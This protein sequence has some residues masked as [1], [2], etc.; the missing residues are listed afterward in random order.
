MQKN[1]LLKIKRIASIMLGFLCLLLGMVFILLPGPAVIFIP[2]GL[3]MLSLEYPWAKIALKKSQGYFRQ[4]AVKT[5]QGLSW[6]GRK[7]GR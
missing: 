3:A 1:R 2:L 4:A 7:L 6:L 5:D